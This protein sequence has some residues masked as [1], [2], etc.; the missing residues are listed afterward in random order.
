ERL[1]AVHGFDVQ[2]GETRT[3]SVDECGFAYRDSVFKQELKDRFVI[4]EVDFALPV[5]WEPVVHYGDVASR[6]KQMGALDAQ[7]ILKAVVQIRTEKLPDPQ[8][9]GNSGSFFKNPVVPVATAHALKSD[10]PELP[11]F[12]VDPGHSKLAAGWL[13][14]QC[15][16]KGFQLGGVQVYPKQAL[17]LTNTGAA[18]GENLSK[19]IQHI[20]AKVEHKFGITLEPE[21]NLI[22]A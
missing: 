9:L 6:C 19:M 13:I 5:Q 11:V 8:S 14:D 2:T 21:P 1:R 3:L 7:T 10:W 12:E 20:Q 17:I 4:T 16:L 15:G 18:T 22:G